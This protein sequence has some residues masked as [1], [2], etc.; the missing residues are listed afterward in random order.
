MFVVQLGRQELMNYVLTLVLAFLTPQSSNTFPPLGIIDFYGLGNVPEK[1]VLDALP[2]HL[3]DTIRVDQFKLK[4]HEMEQNLESIQGVASASLTLVCCA[5]E[6]G[7][8]GKSI[9]YVG[10]REANHQCPEFDPART[11]GGKLT[12]DVLTANH[13][14]DIAFEKSIQEGNFA[15]DDSHGYALDSYPEARQIQLQFV[16]LANVHLMNLKDVLHNSSDA[17]QR[18]IAAQ[19]LGYAKDKQAVVPYLIAAMRDADSDVRN[20]A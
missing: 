2:Y 11:D 1:R 3:G 18:A 5:H 10:I 14:Y 15:E 17:H 9:I 16:K 13:D 7:S 12:P 20:N 4:K 6:D 8:D 19:L